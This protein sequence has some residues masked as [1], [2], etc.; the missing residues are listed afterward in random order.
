[1]KKQRIFTLIEL[2]VVIAIIAILASMLL[3]ALNKARD[4]AK[5]IGC[6]NNLKQLGMAFNM[7]FNDYSDHIPRLSGTSKA[8][9]WTRSLS[10]YVNMD[11]DSLWSD[12][13]G[14]HNNL[15]PAKTGTLFSCL[16]DMEK[17]ALSYGMNRGRN[18]IP[19][20]FST[21]FAKIIHVKNP[22]GKVAVGDSTAWHFFW[23]WNTVVSFRHGQQ[24]N[25]LFFDLH[26]DQNRFPEFKQS[27]IKYP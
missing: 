13:S 15:L 16:G 5:S 3:P 20:D 4:K 17:K 2:L 18:A 10:R 8:P 22:S 9:Y 7:Y 21:S 19:S 1:M 6:K 12:I 11:N 26:V 23:D 24:A 14:N 25:L 27:Y